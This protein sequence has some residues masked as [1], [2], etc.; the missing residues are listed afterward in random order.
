MKYELAKQLK[1]AGF[2][3]DTEWTW[4]RFPDGTYKI[5]NRTDVSEFESGKQMR[6]FSDPTLSELV[7]A[8]GE[9]FY[10]LR[11]TIKWFAAALFAPADIRE[12]W[13]DPPEEA[14]ANLCLTLSKK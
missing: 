5:W 9:D 11:K 4:F 8:C 2:P 12:V 14:V 3:Q 10:H 6:L 7:E 1:D 13:G